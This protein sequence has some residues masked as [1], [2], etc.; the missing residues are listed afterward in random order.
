VTVAYLWVLS[1][2]SK[3]YDIAIDPRFSW[4]TSA[5]AVLREMAQR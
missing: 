4:V 1:G 5:E 3:A 2:D